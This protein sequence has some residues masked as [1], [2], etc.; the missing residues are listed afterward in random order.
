MG[1]ARRPWGRLLNSNSGPAD[2]QKPSDTHLHTRN[3]AAAA[4][5]VVPLA[6]VLRQEGFCRLLEAPWGWRNKYIM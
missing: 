5:A 6:S 3:V 4:A 2:A 1:E